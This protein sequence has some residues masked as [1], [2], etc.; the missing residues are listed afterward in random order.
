MP[1]TLNLDQSYLI[2]IIKDYDIFLIFILLGNV[3]SLM[4]DDDDKRGYQR[5]GSRQTANRPNY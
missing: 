2:Y 1:S 4:K 5:Y 3:L